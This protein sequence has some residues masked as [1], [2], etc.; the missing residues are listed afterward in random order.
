[1][2]DDLEQ[3]F[4]KIISD[5]AKRTAEIQEWAASLPE[6]RCE[7]HGELRALDVQATRETELYGRPRKAVFGLCVK[8]STSQ[9]DEKE[10]AR[11]HA[12][13]VP[14]LLLSATIENWIPKSAKD[15]ENLES[16]LQFMR[17]P[18][19]F[20]VLLGVIG[21]GKSHLAVA[22][23]RQ[24]KSAV[25]VKQSALLRRLRATYADRK[26]VDPIEECQGTGLLVLDDFG[27][28]AGGKDEMPMLHEILDYRHSEFLPTIIT[29]NL[30][31][32][33]LEVLL[34]DRMTDRMSQS[35]FA[36]LSFGGG[37]IRQEKRDEYLE[38]K[39]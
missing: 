16:I 36:V 31:W 24:F 22:V 10:K 33:T 8:C 30:E 27:L 12:Q 38:M 25:F 15:K 37:S 6:C 18:K 34:G 39:L 29:G 35:V 4:Q 11:L 9:G 5:A 1:M 28:S 17:K 32:K 21:T 3:R 7:I 14:K 2:S 19:G 20:L 13:G 23:M 26:A